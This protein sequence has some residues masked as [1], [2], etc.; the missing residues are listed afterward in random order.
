MFSSAKMRFQR[1]E[2]HS[3]HFLVASDNKHII[4]SL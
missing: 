3:G 1:S 4:L 2:S